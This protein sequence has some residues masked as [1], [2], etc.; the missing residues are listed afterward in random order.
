MS[1]FSKFLFL[2]LLI[3]CAASSDAQPG[4][5]AGKWDLT[6]PTPHGVMTLE[7][8]LKQD[9]TAVAGTIL[10]FRSARQPVKGEFKAGQLTLETTDGDE[11][12]LSA[13]M[14][15]DGTLA[16]ELSTPQGDVNWTA[17]RAGKS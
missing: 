6:V 10:N 11:L 13:T 16:G 7:L 15:S 1:I 14:K 8:D 17:K 2:W 4:S 12:A 3:A 5:V 9:D